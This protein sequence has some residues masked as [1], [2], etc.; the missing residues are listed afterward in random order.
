MAPRLSSL[1][2]GSTFSLNIHCLTLFLDR[3]Y[4]IDESGRT[5]FQHRPDPDVQNLQS[6]FKHFHQ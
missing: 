3:M 2:F 1:A 5:A 4:L 6:L